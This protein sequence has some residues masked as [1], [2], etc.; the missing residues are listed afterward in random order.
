MRKVD[1][2]TG[3]AGAANQPTRLAICDKGRAAERTGGTVPRAQRQLFKKKHTHT[4]REKKLQ[5][6]GRILMNCQNKL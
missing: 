2:G 6:R 1:M 3:D 4:Q 5:T